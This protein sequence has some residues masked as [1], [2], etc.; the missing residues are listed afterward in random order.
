[1]AIFAG[2]ALSI[3]GESAG[4]KCAASA[5]PCGRRPGGYGR[6]ARRGQEGRAGARERERETETEFAPFPLTYGLPLRRDAVN[7][8]GI[9]HPSPKYSAEFKQQAVR[10]C[11]ERVGASAENAC[12]L[13][14][15]V[16]GISD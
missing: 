2:I 16:G 3:I 7:G 13:G 5:A 10:L 6:R 11:R 14:F 8:G 1:M 4:W 12:E 15:D 9:G